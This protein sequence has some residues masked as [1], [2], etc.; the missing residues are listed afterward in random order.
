LDDGIRRVSVACAL[1]ELV[2]AAW[3]RSSTRPPAASVMDAARSAAAIGEGLSMTTVP[4]VTTWRFTTS[5]D[6][7]AGP[8]TA[9]GAGAVPGAIASDPVPLLA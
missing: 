4:V 3:L 1:A 8:S 7:V 9:L 5:L 2:A 6:V